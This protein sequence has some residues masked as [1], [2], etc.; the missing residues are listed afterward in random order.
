[1]E[2]NDE[3]ILLYL[4]LVRA[5]DPGKHRIWGNF[6]NVANSLLGHRLVPCKNL[7][8]FILLN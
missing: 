7:W 8:V 1:M 2:V 3:V 4:V 6:L 5:C